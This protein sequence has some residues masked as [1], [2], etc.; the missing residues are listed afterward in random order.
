VVEVVRVAAEV[1]VVVMGLSANVVVML[2]QG[3]ELQDLGLVDT[4]QRVKVL[5]SV[6]NRVDLLLGLRILRLLSGIRVRL[7]GL[8]RLDL[9]PGYLILLLVV[10]LGFY[11][12]VLLRQ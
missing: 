8:D 9:C 4:V 10:L 2:V 11:R 5:R 7:D 1:V 6:V 12:L 3:L